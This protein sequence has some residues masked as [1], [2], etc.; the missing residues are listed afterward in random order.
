MNYPGIG[1]ISR[2]FPSP[3][4]IKRSTLRKVYT[5][6]WVHG[7]LRKPPPLWYLELLKPKPLNPKFMLDARSA[8]GT[9][10][11]ALRAFLRSFSGRVLG[12]EFGV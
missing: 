6:I 8:E 12:L 2:I 3:P 10:A 11:G 4:S 7:P 1:S 9:T 5:T